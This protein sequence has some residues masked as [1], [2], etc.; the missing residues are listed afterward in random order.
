MAVVLGVDP[1]HAG[2]ERVRESV[3]A[4][5]V[6]GPEIARQAV[7]HVVCERERLVL[8]LERN[9]GQHGPEDLFLRDT[10][11]IVRAR[12]NRRLYVVS[13][14]RGRA[15]ADRYRYAFAARDA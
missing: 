15:T 6:V 12:E 3:R 4:A 13:A 11:A 10:H 2:L 1:D 5:H 8:V 7:A 9:H 14:L